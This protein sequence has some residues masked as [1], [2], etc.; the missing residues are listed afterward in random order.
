MGIKRFFLRQ[1]EQ[2]LHPTPQPHT[3]DTVASWEVSQAL[4]LK[5]WKVWCMFHSC[6]NVRLR[7][8]SRKRPNNFLNSWTSWNDGLHSVSAQG[9]ENPGKVASRFSMNQLEKY[10]CT[11]F[12]LI[13][14]QAVKRTKKS[15]KYH[16][17]TRGVRWDTC[18]LDSISRVD[19]PHH[20]TGTSLK[21]TQ[22]TARLTPPIAAGRK[23]FQLI[24]DRDQS[25][26][27]VLGS[28]LE[29]GKLSRA[30]SPGWVPRPGVLKANMPQRNEKAHPTLCWKGCPLTVTQRARGSWH[31][32]AQGSS[33]EYLS[34]VCPE[35]RSDGQ[36]E[37][38][39]VLADLKLPKD[40]KLTT[41]QVVQARTVYFQ[42]GLRKKNN[43]I[44][45]QSYWLACSYLLLSGAVLSNWAF[46]C[47]RSRRKKKSTW[48]R[49][50]FSKAQVK[51]QSKHAE[52]LPSELQGS[53][54]H[55]DF[56]PSEI[57]KARP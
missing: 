50:Y 53:P 21:L 41:L 49:Y 18:I 7:T 26:E 39:G 54:L 27:N 23:V 24:S 17:K 9:V 16:Y 14:Q 40:V 43:W 13:Y 42:R 2:E 11:N 32:Q 4:L 52:M 31:S 30:L 19:F 37:R 25:R 47:L 12:F 10:P 33:V 22:G 56:W 45:K 44:S 5:N 29:R 35:T 48:K 6:T 8:G 20:L 15:I 57:L 1:T 38:T 51:I 3:L 28:G 46:K 34:K 36:N 55:Q